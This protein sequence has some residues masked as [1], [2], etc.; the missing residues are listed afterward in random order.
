M[1][2]EDF[3][4][5]QVLLCPSMYAPLLEDYFTVFPR[6][7]IHVVHADYYY[8]NATDE[9]RKVYRFLGVREY[10]MQPTTDGH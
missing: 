7:Q 8:R 10:E 4:F 5:W 2:L 1:K 6:H 3:F 9:L